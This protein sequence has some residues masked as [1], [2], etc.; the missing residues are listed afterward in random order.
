MQR[1]GNSVETNSVAG[2]LAC[3][4]LVAGFA[5]SDLL[6]CAVQCAGRLLPR[7]RAALRCSQTTKQRR[8]RMRRG[9]R[10]VALRSTIFGL[11]HVAD[12]DFAGS[13]LSRAAMEPRPCPASHSSRTSPLARMSIAGVVESRTGAPGHSWRVSGFPLWWICAT[14][15]DPKCRKSRPLRLRRAHR[16][17]RSPAATL[18]ELERSTSWSTPQGS[19]ASTGCASLSCLGR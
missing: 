2:W 12:A 18:L 4:F 10:T 8:C 6:T 11:P 9:Y 19:F 1:S 13:R 14:L 3:A 16:F 5:S 17:F 7:P 15:A